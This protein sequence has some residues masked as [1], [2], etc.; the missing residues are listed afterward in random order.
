MANTEIKRVSTDEQ[1]VSDRTVTFDVYVNG[2]Y[3]ATFDDYLDAEDY[4]NAE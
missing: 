1:N 3:A 2:Q 4:I